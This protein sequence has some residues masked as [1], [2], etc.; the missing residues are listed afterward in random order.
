MGVRDLYIST[1][2]QHVRNK[3]TGENAGY[4]SGEMTFY[5]VSA[6][7]KFLPEEDKP[8]LPKRKLKIKVLLK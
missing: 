2:L 8:M 7:K 5:H 6:T 4:A 1:G 3:T